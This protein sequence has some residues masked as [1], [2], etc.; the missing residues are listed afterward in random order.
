MS[1]LNNLLV[2]DD[3]TL[4][5]FSRVTTSAQGPEYALGETRETLDGKRYRY[6][7]FKDAVTYVAGHCVTWADAT[8]LTTVT[9]DI[10]GGS[11]IGSIP[12]GVC[13]GVPAQNGY[14]WILV[15]GFHSAV[16]TSGADD[17]AV[18]ENVFVHSSTDGAVD[19][20]AASA[21]TTTALGIAVAAD[22]DA[23]NTVAVFVNV[24]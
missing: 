8:S 1:Y 2:P 22:V 21:V 7:Q 23:A 15:R 20:T 11:S 19:G 3:G 24:G 5:G 18:G 10:S 13:V 9:N 4:T 6:V 12:A 17:I 16:V 14:G